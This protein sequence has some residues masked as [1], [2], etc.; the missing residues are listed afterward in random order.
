MRWI[1]SRFEASASFLKKEAKNFSRVLRTLSD[2]RRRHSDV[3][4]PAALEWWHRPGARSNGEKFFGSF[5][6]KRTASFRFLPE[7]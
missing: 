5:F 2:Q 6:Q 1:R 7:E 4:M 3:G